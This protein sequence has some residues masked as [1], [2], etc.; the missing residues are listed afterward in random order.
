MRV[1]GSYQLES[2]RIGV[3]YADQTLRQTDESDV[4]RRLLSAFVSGDVMDQVALFL[5]VD[6][7]FDPNPAGDRIAFIPF[8]P[9]AN[10][11]FI[12]AGVEWNP[13]KD[14]FFTP[15]FEYISYGQ[16]SAGETPGDDL[17]GRVTFF[18]KFK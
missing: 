18:W 6:R 13:I 12:L 8:D 11:I 2:F 17:Y 4:K 16:N 7:M 15:N 9:T 14:V 10:S 5:R 1:F 3:E